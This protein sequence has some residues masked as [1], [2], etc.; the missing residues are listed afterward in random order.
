MVDP[1]NRDPATAQ[2]ENPQAGPGGGAASTSTGS[3]SRANAFDHGLR[4][5]IVFSDEMAQAILERTKMLEEQFLPEGE[6]ENSSIHDMAVARV[7]LDI[8][9]DLLVARADR[10]VNRARG[11][12]DFDRRERAL[13]LLRRLPKNPAYLAHKLAGTK[14]GALLMVERW[15]GLAQAAQGAGDWDDAQRQLAHD[16]LGTALELRTSTSAL[17]PAG[18]GAALAALAARQIACLHTAIDQVLGSQD[19]QDRANTIAGF[20]LADDDETRCLRRY[21]SMA[22]RDYNRAHAE[23]LQAQ[24]LADLERG[25]ADEDFSANLPSIMDLLRAE[26]VSRSW[27]PGTG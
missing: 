6:Y 7:K 17:P 2:S 25:D 12:W 8:A 15:E 5:K 23:L 11:F 26:P 27:G 22:R 16:L 13:K 3:G 4:A 20:R 9:A 1:H 21:E 18:A 19:A 14:Q 24:E 10:V